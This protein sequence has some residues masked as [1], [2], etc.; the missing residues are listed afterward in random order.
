M[1][2]TD[3]IT[4]MREFFQRLFEN[5]K[6]GFLFLGGPLDILVAVLDIV[7]TSFIIYYLLKLLRDSRAW[8]LLKGILLIIVLAF[9]S[10]M[11]GLSSLGFLLNRTI[12]ILAIAIVVIFQPELRRALETVGRSSFNVLTQVTE[13]DSESITSQLIESIVTACH[14][15]SETRTGALIVIE[16][17]TP[18]GDLKSQE[19]AV[20]LDAVLSATS[21]QQ[22]FY[23]GSPLHDGAVLIRDGKI[24]AA[25]IHIPLSDNYHLRR[26]LGTRHRA[27]IGASEMG[28]TIA[29]V[30]SEERGTISMAVDG[31]LYVLDNSDAL[32]TH[33]HRLLI[34][35]TD[36]QRFS[37]LRRRPET[38]GDTAPKKQ[39]AALV[40]LS[41]LISMVL[42]FFVQV[43]VNPL[44]TKVYTVPLQYDAMLDMREKGFEIQYPVRSIQVTL[45][46]RKNVLDKLNTRDITAYLD[47]NEV[48]TEGLQVLDVHV[49]TASTLYTRVENMNPSVMTLAV[50]PAEYLAE[51]EAEETP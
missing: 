18:L 50:R 41:V 16:R 4:R 11:I 17:S 21:L 22:I 19:N 51:D 24:A 2:N 32:R 1:P 35:D 12:S 20:V 45:K 6:D 43:Q 47:L 46:A 9:T 37:F 26:D 3:L 27:A 30:C 15:M 28:D 7:L 36:G 5:L 29:V 49:A 42:W 44:E 25:R 8:Q 48:E 34:R 33:L 39:R 31:R 23:L 40:A 38:T 13:G 10:S 14:N